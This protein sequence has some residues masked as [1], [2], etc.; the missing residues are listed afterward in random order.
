MRIL[1][2][3]R[4]LREVGRI[5]I[6]EQVPTSNGKSRPKKLETFRLTSRDQFVIEAAAEQWGGT[7]QKWEG[8]PTEDQWEVFTETAS[9]SVVVPPGDMSF[10]QA[11]EVWSAGGCK[12]RCDGRWDHLA[13]KACHCDPENRACDI[14]TRLSV[15]LP[16]LPGIGVWRLDTQGY[17]AAVELGGIVDLVASHSERGIMLPARLRLEQ[18]SVKRIDAGKVVTRNFAVPVLDVDVHPLALTGGGVSPSSGELAGPVRAALPA[19]SITPVPT[20]V[21]GAGAPSIA[22]QMAGI[23]EPQPKAARANAARPIPATGV[24]PRTARDAA[25][26]AAAPQLDPGKVDRIRTQLNELGADARRA[27]LAEFGCRP[28]ELR[29]EQLDAA[30]K[31]VTDMAPFDGPDRPEVLSAPGSNGEGV[32]GPDADPEPAIP[33]LDEQTGPEPAISVR[34]V[35]VYAQKV[36]HADYEAAPNGDKTRT[37]DRL[38]HALAHKV[39]KG[40]TTSAKDLTVVELYEVWGSLARLEDGTDKYTVT[41]SGVT[42][43]A[44]TTGRKTTVAWADLEAEAA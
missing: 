23:D 11:Y 6:G 5:R 27:F 29:V 38:R 8:A 40:R 30:V 42:F 1:D 35:A 20:V 19:G 12:A 41:D 13:D 33:G 18:R 25:E 36:F 32:V 21:D 16:D 31:F 44:G 28:V 34:D 24:K 7:A 2:L 17:Y 14:H 39:S 26:G 9:L 15:I 37:V 22:E 10:S 3:Q 43:K 4:R